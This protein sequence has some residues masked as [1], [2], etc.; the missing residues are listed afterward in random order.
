MLSNNCKGFRGVGGN[1]GGGVATRGG[2]AVGRGVN[3]NGVDC[4]GG[5]PYMLLIPAI[6]RGVIFCLFG[7]IDIK[8]ILNDLIFTFFFNFFI[9]LIHL[10]NIITHNINIIKYYYILLY[11]INELII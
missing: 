4:D 7:L 1:A 2:I 5:T 3:V 6:L 10:L 9:L 8:I 11:L